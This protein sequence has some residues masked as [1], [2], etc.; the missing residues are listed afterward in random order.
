MFSAET[1]Q[2]AEAEDRLVLLSVGTAWC[3]WC[4]VMDDETFGDADVAALIAEHFVAVKVDAD[5]RPDLA[6]RYRRWAWPATAVLT[7]DAQ[8]V[9]T[10][11][12]YRGPDVFGDLLRE[13]VADK[14]AG[15]PLAREAPPPTSPPT[16]SFP[17]IGLAAARD[18]GEALLDAEWDDEGG[19]W[20]TPQKYP[21]AE[22]ILHA[23]QRSRRTGDP[24]HAERA[25][26]ALSLQRQL[27]DPVWGGIYQY[28]ERGRWDRPHYEK[29]A[30]VQAGAMTAAAEGV[31]ISEFGQREHLADIARYVR[32]FLTDDRGAF[33]TSQDADAGDIPGDV[34]YAEDDAGRRA[35]GMPRIDR[36]AYADRNGM[37]ISAHL[38]AYG[39]T[40][41]P[42]H[43][44]AALRAAEAMSTSHRGASGGWRHDAADD[45]VRY[46]ADQAW[47]GTALLALYETTGEARWLASAR[48]TVQVLRHSLRTEQGG[49]RARSGPLATV[50]I[51]AEPRIPTIENAVA[52][53]FLIRFGR[54]TGESI[55]VLTGRIALRRVSTPDRI[56]SAGRNVGHVLLALEEA[57]AD[58][59]RVVAIGEESA[60]AE[61][62]ADVRGASIHHLLIERRAP[63]E[64]YPPV[65]GAAVFVCADGAC[66][67]PISDRATLAVVLDGL[68]VAP[69]LPATM[70]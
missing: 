47:M 59:P 28:S 51:F 39:A 2:R 32:E 5:A 57:L 38:E 9:V 53:R 68:A 11:R 12:G 40:G 42:A 43:L 65:E 31:R 7:P 22:P 63:G 46:L 25:L 6:E 66:S 49:F 16:A 61:L 15:Q 8:P 34:Y 3:H 69:K 45:S 54:L 24:L 67:P 62:L 30:I 1:L 33:L 27:V 20:G 55:F 60:L 19:G 64:P 41:D 37:L 52:A 58:P 21:R 56:R 35:L 48:E 10:L 17:P 23:L 4:H 26:R 29:I 50:G 13:I 44:A 14:R 18:A 70:R 36:T